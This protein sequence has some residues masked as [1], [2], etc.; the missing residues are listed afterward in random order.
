MNKLLQLIAANGHASVQNRGP[1]NHDKKPITLLVQNASKPTEANLYIYDIITPYA[2]TYWGGISAKMVLDAIAQIE[3]PAN[4]TLNVH[5]NS[6]GGDV[7]EGRAIRTA[8]KNYAGPV[9]GHIDALAASAATTVADGCDTCDIATGAFFMIHNSW[10]MA[11]GDKQDMTK[12]AD[13]LAKIDQAIAAD[14]QQRTGKDLSQIVDWMT[15]E[16]WFSAE[17][18]VAQGFCNAIETTTDHTTPPDTS[19]KNTWNLGAYN[20][21]PK[22]LTT[23]ALNPDEPTPDQQAKEWGEHIN[24]RMTLVNLNLR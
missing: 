9:H 20:H 22:A 16:T 15:Q 19:N 7:F 21:A 24:R 12:T 3:T 23:P 17:E 8:L 14:Y 5:I 18:A 10:T 2:D 4:T 6:P 11:Y 1:H 13:L